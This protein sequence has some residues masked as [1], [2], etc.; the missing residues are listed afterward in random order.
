MAPAADPFIGRDLLSGQFRILERIGA[1]GMGVVYTALQPEMNR[2]VAVKVLN[3]K[4]S[5]RKDLAS[6]LRREARAMSQMSH[7]SI[8]KVFLHGELDGC[9]YVV[10]ELL[11]GRNLKDAIRAEGSFP[12]ERALPILLAVCGALAEAHAAGI[13]H[14]DLKPDNIFLCR[15]GALVDFP[16]VLDFGLA[17]VT[18]NQMRPGS[19]VLTGDHE[20]FGTPRYMSPEQA[21]GK[22]LTPS[23]DIYSLALVLYETLTGQSPFDARDSL[24]YTLLHVK[25]APVPL[26]VRVAGKV[27]PRELEAIVMKALAKAP[28]DRYASATEFAAALHGVLES[29]YLKPR[30]AIGST[31]AAGLPASS[32]APLASAGRP[33]AAKR[34]LVIGL[35]AAAFVLGVLITVALMTTVLR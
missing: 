32:L 17:K 14:R 21:Q 33:A 13:I 15:S 25:V 35:I 18:E 11:E 10:M 12:V 27:F 1:G 8:A 26:S 6:R 22:P 28:E 20:V 24:E 5:A 3:P 23:S 7:P 34:G 29:L 9:L 2:K 31:P 4:L 30:A 19:V 16:K